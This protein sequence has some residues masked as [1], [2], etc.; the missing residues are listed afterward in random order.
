[1]IK[2]KPFQLKQKK[3]RIVHACGESPKPQI[4]QTLKFNTCTIVVLISTTNQ[5][6]EVYC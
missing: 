3:T 4:L 6:T 1:M 2:K 5:E